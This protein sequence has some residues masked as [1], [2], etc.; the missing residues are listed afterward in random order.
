MTTLAMVFG[1][2]AA[3]CFL[4]IVVMAALAANRDLD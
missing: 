3:G 2:F 1:A 4:G